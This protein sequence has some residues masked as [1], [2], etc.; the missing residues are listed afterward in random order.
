MRRLGKVLHVSN[1][2]GRLIVRG[3]HG[4]QV[5]KKGYV[6]D[7][8]GHVIGTI[9]EVFGPVARPYY[10]VKVPRTAGIEAYIDQNVFVLIRN[11]R[12]QHRRNH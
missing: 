8:T 2:T 10:A 11:E 9:D 3:A 4:D 1:V 6:I 7:G 5:E 12:K